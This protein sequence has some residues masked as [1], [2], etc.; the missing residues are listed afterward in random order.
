MLKNV[1]VIGALDLKQFFDSGATGIIEGL[2]FLEGN[3]V[4]IFRMNDQGWPD[5]G[6]H[7]FDILKSIRLAYSQ[8]CRV[9]AQ[10]A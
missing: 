7:L 4:I 8:R 1:I 6:A 2:S 5:N 10:E 3:D 9:D